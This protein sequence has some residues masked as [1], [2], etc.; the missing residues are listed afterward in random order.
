[1]HQRKA[2]FIA[3]DKNPETLDIA[4]QYI[5]SAV[6]N[7]TL[8]PATRKFEARQLKSDSL[9]SKDGTQNKVRAINNYSNNLDK[10]Q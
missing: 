6:G 7:Q 9:E 5:E 4:I 10:H 8:V 1:M 2:A 3:M